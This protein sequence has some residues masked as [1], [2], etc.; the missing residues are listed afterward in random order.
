MVAGEVG[1]PSGLALCEQALELVAEVAEV[2]GIG[3]G[4]E[5]LVDHGREVGEGS[6][7]WVRPSFFGLATR[8]KPLIQAEVLST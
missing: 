5:E 7:G 2:V 6:C 3:V 1:R 4:S 8:P